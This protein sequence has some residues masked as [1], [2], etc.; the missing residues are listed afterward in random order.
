MQ[1]TPV[2]PIDFSSSTSSP[3]GS[4]HSSSMLS[5]QQNSAD[6]VVA[7]LTPAAPV[8]PAKNTQAS[9][10]VEQVRHML[11]PRYQGVDVLTINRFIAAT[12]GNLQ[13]SAKRLAA[14]C[15]WREQNQPEKVVCKACAK[16]PKSHFMHVIGHDAL[17][18]PIIYSCLAAAK[19]KVYQDNH[20]HMIATF[21][22]AIKL[23]PPGVQNWVWVC[24]FEGFGMA[25]INPALAKAFLDVSAT[26]YPERLGLFCVVDAPSLFGVLWRAIEK[27]VDP[28]TYTKIRFL[29]FD[30]KQGPKSSLR[31][32]LE[33]FCTPD[34]AHWIMEEMVENRDSKKLKSKTYNM[35]EIHQS[36]CQG[37]LVPL[38]P[39]QHD[40]RGTPQLLG[41]YRQNPTVLEPLAPLP[42][43]TSTPTA[44]AQPHR[45]SLFSRH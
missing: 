13:L 25:D 33:S 12:N 28:K 43:P 34:M 39:P 4:P 19:N 6:L 40:C 11:P 3:G 16:N 44:A 10:N 5:S 18:R 42:S 45:Y 35:H 8:A 32:S 14:T 9:A 2:V 41:M 24:D 17:Q 38:A 27:F 23:M 21:E 1:A 29:P 37:S 15:A 30:L 22:K 20:D 26:H 31:Q 7:Q 36:A